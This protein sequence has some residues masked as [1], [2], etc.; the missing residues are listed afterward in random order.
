MADHGAQA[1]R[2]LL[3]WLRTTLATAAVLATVGRELVFT[4]RSWEVWCW[5][6]R[7]SPWS[8]RFSPAAATAPCRGPRT[9]GRRAA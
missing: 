1:E 3:A 2:T 9:R 4:T 8:W 6:A 5:P 7:R